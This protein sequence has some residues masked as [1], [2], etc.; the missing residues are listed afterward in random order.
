MA[1]G[2][3]L[4]G[5][6]LRE[7][8]PG[9]AGAALGSNAPESREPRKSPERHIGRGGPTHSCS[10]KITRAEPT[11]RKPSLHRT[12]N[13]CQPPP[14]LPRGTGDRAS[15]AR[16]GLLPSSR[17]LRPHPQS[18]ASL[19]AGEAIDARCP[20]RWGATDYLGEATLESTWHPR[21]PAGTP[22]SHPAPPGPTRHPRVP[23]G[24]GAARTSFHRGHTCMTPKAEGA[25]TLSP[26]TAA[27]LAVAGGLTQL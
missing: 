7:A 8:L 24:T 19:S 4:G 17:A 13:P 1:Q 22:A 23:P 10:Q 3:S 16:A 25:R 26:V 27:G 12:F 5:H 9:G 15:T 11:W 2:C 18:G 6:G 20:R 14:A 21:V